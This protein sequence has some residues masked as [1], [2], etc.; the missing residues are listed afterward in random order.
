M[1]RWNGRE[2]NGTKSYGVKRPRGCLCIFL[3][4][5]VTAQQ[6]LESAGLKSVLQSLGGWDWASARLAASLLLTELK[7]GD[8]AVWH[9][10]FVRAYHY[11][12]LRTGE[13]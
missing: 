8:H 7:D 4:K 1:T 11:S 12:K 13:G 2:A 10:V 3:S 6:R 9:A 5:M